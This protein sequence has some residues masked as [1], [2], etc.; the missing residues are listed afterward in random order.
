MLADLISVY[1]CGSRR[2]RRRRRRSKRSAGPAGVRGT[3]MH[4]EL[5]NENE[6]H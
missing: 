6:S 1:G 5:R 2:G 4:P 3:L